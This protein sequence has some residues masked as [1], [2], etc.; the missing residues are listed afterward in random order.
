VHRE[1]GQI[2]R[3]TVKAY[4]V[5]KGFGFIACDDGGP[6]VFL[7]QSAI[8]TDGF[9]C[10]KAG[11]KCQFNY[12]L[13]EGKPTATKLAGRDGAPLPIYQTKKDAMEN[14]D[15][16]ALTGSVKWFNKERGFGFIVQDTGEPDMFVH[17]GQCEGLH[18][19]EGQKVTY[20]I[21]TLQNKDG[22]TKLTATDVKVKGARPQAAAAFA[23]YGYPMYGFPPFGA[24]AA[25]PAPVFRPPAPMPGQLQTGSVKWFNVAKSFGFIIPSTGGDELYVSSKCVKSPPSGQLNENDLVEYTVHTSPEGKMWATNVI[26]RGLGVANGVG[27]KRKGEYDAGLGFKA[28][29][30][31]YAQQ[32]AVAPQAYAQPQENYYAAPAVPVYPAYPEPQREWAYP[33]APAATPAYAP[34]W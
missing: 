22:T 14:S 29:R 28:P 15:P 8:Q 32:Y 12:T 16:N 20:K 27:Q 26:V 3:G 19:E 2:I 25:F 23:A 5:D 31:D 21:K 6:D 33:A 7:H 11:T 13:R 30:Q 10:V 18:L 24:P 17:V 34:A 1:E 9:R 4:Y